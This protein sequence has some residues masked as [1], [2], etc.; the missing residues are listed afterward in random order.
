MVH[1]N[2][3]ELACLVEDHVGG[4]REYIPGIA[5]DAVFETNDPIEADIL[6]IYGSPRRSN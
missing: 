1:R 4:I 5:G 3:E 2:T 6:T